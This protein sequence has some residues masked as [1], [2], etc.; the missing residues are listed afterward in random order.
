M[1]KQ[2]RQT[3]SPTTE[4]GHNTDSTIQVFD[5]CNASTKT[6]DPFTTDR[7][8]FY[9]MDTTRTTECARGDTDDGDLAP[10][11]SSCARVT[12]WSARLS[13]DSWS[14]CLVRRE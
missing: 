10:I 8:L 5:N 11:L 4:V 9:A 13:P 3:Q 14:L 2:R 1:T 12:P 6:S 7:M